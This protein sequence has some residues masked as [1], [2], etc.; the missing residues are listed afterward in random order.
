MFRLPRIYRPRT[1]ILGIIMELLFLGIPIFAAVT[2][3]LFF[4]FYVMGRVYLLLPL[5]VGGIWCIVVFFGFFLAEPVHPTTK[6][7]AAMTSMASLLASESTILTSFKN[8]NIILIVVSNIGC[9]LLLMVLFGALMAQLLAFIAP[10]AREKPAQAK[11]PGETAE[12][13]S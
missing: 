7:L 4:Q 5:L 8:I 11:R 10:L 13:F 12:V 3:D 6:A 2:P 9:L 1:L